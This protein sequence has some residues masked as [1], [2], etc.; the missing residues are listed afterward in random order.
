MSEEDYSLDEIAD[1]Q[2][3]S[4][5][6]NVDPPFVEPYFTEDP[7]L[8]NVWF[9]SDIEDSPPEGS[10]TDM[11]SDTPKGVIH[12]PDS[13]FHYF[14]DFIGPIYAFLENCIKNNIEEVEIIGLILEPR[15]NV[16]ENFD[17]FLDHCLNKFSGR[18]KVKYTPLNQN[19]QL[20]TFDHAYIR[21]NKFRI[22]DQQDIGASL[23][24][25]YES[26]KTFA[27][28]SDSTVPSKKVF[29]SR[30]NDLVKDGAPT[31]HMH[32]DEVEDFLS[33]IGFE[34]I[35]GEMF[36]TLEEQ[37]KYFEDVS[38]FAG[39]T[40]AGLTSSIFMKPGQK[41]VEIV[42]PLIFVSGG[43]YE[44]H[45]F[46][47]TISLLK[48]HSYIGLSNINNNKEDLLRQLKNIAKTF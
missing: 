32:Q 37:M 24:F 9:Y 20:S 26:T 40:G 5:Y 6:I 25:I 22:I 23:E 46:Y 1:K 30:K 44:I 29:I 47:K 41:V 11:V 18:I 15:Q 2:N 19:S 3:F 31:R 38:V 39:F 45:N 36:D 43:Q 12:V 42:C 14:P 33:S 8:L 48:K 34:V 13:Y 28:H 17:P 4:T 10:I 35:N 7:S 27:K 21:I 16:V